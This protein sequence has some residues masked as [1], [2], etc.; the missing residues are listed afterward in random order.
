MLG[1]ARDA[2]PVYGSGGFTSYSDRQLR[3]QL[4]GWAAEGIPRVKMKVGADPARDLD[5]V[6][7]ARKAVGDSVELFVDANGAYSRKQALRFADEF[8]G[9]GSAGSRSRCRP[10]TSPACGYSA[11]AV[12]PG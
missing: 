4:G 9:S 10:T 2:A 11:T 12:R 1:A 5:R 8:A 7:V 3:D 6:R